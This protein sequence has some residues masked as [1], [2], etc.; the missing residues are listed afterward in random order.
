MRKAVK[1]LSWAL[2]LILF[3]VIAVL[4]SGYY[5]LHP[6][7]YKNFDWNSVKFDQA[8]S[9]ELAAKT[10]FT[11]ITFNAGFLD[12]RI[13]GKTKFMPTD[14]IEARLAATPTHLLARDADLIA[15]QEV[16]EKAHIDFLI[17]ELKPVYPHYYFQHNSRL[18]LN[19]G[20]MLFSKYPLNDRKG[21]SQPEKGPLDERFL[22][23]RSLLSAVVEIKG[24]RISIV[25]LHAT[26]G[27]TLYSS[28]DPKINAMRGRQL[29]T[30]IDLA[31]SKDTDYE[32]ILGDIN[33]GPIVSRENYQLFSY[34]S[35]V[36]THWAYS[37][38]AITF[39]ETTWA[40][41]NYHNAIRG[42]AADIQQRI[43]L[44]FFSDSL[45][46]EAVLT[47][48]QR[49]YTEDSVEIDD[50]LSVPLSDHYGLEVSFEFK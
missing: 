13:Q 17:E 27:G 10:D 16:Y 48:A 14:H 25:N 3:L 47:N 36:D 18:K 6:K 39:P 46:A 7:P 31:G 12:L 37:G 30:A 29:Q 4:V 28:D 21:M 8:V 44:I 23:D 1:F 41:D 5:T 9:P 20:L 11:L 49:L 15:F 24:K 34:N 40:G 38:G 35:Y 45:A 19:N 50:N 2:V 43:D 26:S 22:A 33:A 32:I 42:Y